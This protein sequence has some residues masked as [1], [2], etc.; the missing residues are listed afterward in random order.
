MGS[1]KFDKKLCAHHRNEA[2]NSKNDLTVS[3]KETQ[4]TNH[5]KLPLPSIQTT[6]NRPTVMYHCRELTHK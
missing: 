6:I 3:E 5:S 2:I 1:E 4:V